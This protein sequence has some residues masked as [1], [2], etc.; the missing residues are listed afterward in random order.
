MVFQMKK[1]EKLLKHHNHIVFLDFEGTQYS[2]EMIAIGAVAVSLDKNGFIKRR[3]KPFKIYVK[4]KNKIGKYVVELTGIQEETLKEQGVC[5]RKAM[6]ELKKYV[7]LSFKK[8]SFI[9]YGNHDMKILGQSIS[10]NMDFP[11]EICSQIQ[12]NYIDYATFINEF[13]RDE[14]GNPLSLVHNCEAFG[15]TLAGDA[16]DPAVDA[17][18]LANL[19]DAFLKNPALVAENYKK[20]LPHVN[21]FP[22][23]VNH[24]LVKLN[25][26]ESV[27]PETFDEEIKDYLS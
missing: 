7:G 2:H 3:K 5:F 6:E 15:L 25:N 21:H 19:Y 9:T 14:N 13:M 26:G 17:E 10:Y 16:H 11:K 8:S 24:I 20:V 27:S 23:P 22:E 12:K 4:A 18:N 1:L